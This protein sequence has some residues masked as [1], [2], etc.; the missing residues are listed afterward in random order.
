[1][2]DI[3]THERERGRGKKEKEKERDPSELFQIF[4]GLEDLF[5]STRDHTLKARDL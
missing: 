4:C 3:H 5:D 1:M 2:E